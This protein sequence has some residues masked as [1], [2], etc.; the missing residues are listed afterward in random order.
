MREKTIWNDEAT[1]AWMAGLYEGEGSI[2]AGP[3]KGRS[4]L[5][6]MQLRIN[7][8][9]QD[10]V[11]RAASAAVVGV[12]SGP[13]RSPRSPGHHKPQWRWVVGSSTDVERVA[14]LLY[15]LLGRR[16]REQID[17]ALELWRSQ[18]GPI[19]V[20]G[21]LESFWGRVEED[22]EHWLWRG[23]VDRF[24]FGS[25]LDREGHRLQAHRFACEQAGW[26][27]AGRR[28]R[29][30]CGFKHCVKPDHWE[31]DVRLSDENVAEIRQRLA[32]GETGASLSREFGVS[33]GVVSNIRTGKR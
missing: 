28:L 26:D 3:Q 7:M 24:G 11:E 25:L 12:L 17:E 4:H 22:G 8:T 32:A 9:D 15:P 2:W 33:S 31:I 19:P 6:Y 10:V 14:L 21:M 1:K 18:A 13:Y 16:R 23:G 29:N 30:E 27:I 20:A 5:V